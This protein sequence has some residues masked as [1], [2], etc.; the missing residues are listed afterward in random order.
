MGRESTSKGKVGKKRMLLATPWRIFSSAILLLLSIQFI[1]C[2]SLIRPSLEPFIRYELKPSSVAKK[3]I[4]ARFFGATTIQIDDGETA[5]MIDGFLSRPGLIQLLFADLEPDQ[6]RIDAGLISGNVSRLSAVLV[7]HSH[8][9]HAMDSAVVADKTNA[10]LIGSNSTINIGRGYMEW[11]RERM[12]IPEC[13]EILQ[14]GTFTVQF[15][16]SPHSPDFPYPGQITHPLVTPAPVS[17][18][19]EGGNYSFLLRHALG[20]ILAHTSANYTPALFKNVK[21]DVVFLSI[22]LLGKQTESFAREYWREVV[23]TTGAKLV[24]PIHWDDLTRPLDQPL[25]PMPYI[26][27]NFKLAMEI[28]LKMAKED[29]VQIGFMPL[30]ESIDLLDEQL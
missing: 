3:A 30:F 1:G 4:H 23:R 12:R 13:K 6:A 9:D 26:I 18:Y 27:D 25:L 16:E 10:L 11:S 28:L 29:E 8:Y 20:T 24:I 22:G 7:S 15:F 2:G 14:L 19:R 21:A 17:S 5:I